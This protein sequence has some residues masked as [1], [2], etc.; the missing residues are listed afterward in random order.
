MAKDPRKFAYE[1]HS[2]ERVKWVQNWTCIVPGCEGWP[3]ENHHTRAGGMGMKAHYSTIVPLCFVH[4]G[5]I[6]GPN[7][8]RKTFEKRFGLDLRE[9]AAE[10]ERRWRDYV[11]AETDFLE[12]SDAA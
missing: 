5:M 8:G 6:H 11:R 10:V 7:C 3:C 4:H 12:G 2:E 1:Y 9:E